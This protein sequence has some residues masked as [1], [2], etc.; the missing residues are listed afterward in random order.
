M[1]LY[2]FS[3]LSCSFRV[4]K[5][6]TISLFVKILNSFFVKTCGEQQ[7]ISCLI[8][9]RYSKY[10]LKYLYIFTTKYLSKEV[11]FVLWIDVRKHFHSRG[12]FL[13]QTFMRG[14]EFFLMLFRCTYCSPRGTKAKHECDHCISI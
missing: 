2:T 9:R 3:V 14:V 12:I 4:K 10:N 13:H 5:V 11:S 8:C 7:L 6:K 1:Q